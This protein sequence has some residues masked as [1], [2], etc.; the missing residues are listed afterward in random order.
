MRA[1]VTR[2]KAAGNG[3]TLVELLVAISIMAIVAIISW[4]G[5]SALVATRDRLGPE[6]DE[7]RALLTGFGQMQLD[8]AHVPNPQLVPLANPPVMLETI[9][10]SPAL[11]LLR[12]SEPLADGGSALQQVTYS[13]VDG[14]LIRAASPPARTV[15]LATTATPSTVRLVP[16]VASMQI[17]AW[18]GS[19]GW[20]AAGNTP[21]PPQGIEVVVTRND[22]TRLRRVLLVG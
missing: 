3:F 19:E 4:R 22:G 7:V 16:G 18:R 2:V 21:I 5:L 9:G 6:A 8:L 20:V 1:A 15:E 17:R 14:A 10:G 11:Q 13:V 12:F